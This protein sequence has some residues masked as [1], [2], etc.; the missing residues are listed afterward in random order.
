MQA[1]LIL[2]NL[3]ILNLTFLKSINTFSNSK[4]LKNPF[5]TFSNPKFVTNNTVKQS[6][7]ENSNVHVIKKKLY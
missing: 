3:L 2:L 7:I 4:Y 5:S 1:K 6:Y